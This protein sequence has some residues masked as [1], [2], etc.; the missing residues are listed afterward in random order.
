V[1]A[2]RPALLRLAAVALVTL[3]LSFLVGRDG[4]PGWQAVRVLEAVLAA[5]LAAA[6]IL[7]LGR[8]WRGL[9]VLLVRIAGTA[10]GTGISVQWTP[11]AGVGAVSGAGHT[12]GLAT[13]ADEWEGRVLGFLDA[14]LLG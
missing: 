12:G 11:K 9:A 14:E 1:P 13:A 3:P 7:A 4:S 10:V 6:A 8:R 5:A 2:P